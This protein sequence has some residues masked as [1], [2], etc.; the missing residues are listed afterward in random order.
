MDYKKSPIYKIPVKNNI[1]IEEDTIVAFTDSLWNDY[2]DTDRSTGGNCTV[3][4][5]GPVDYISHLPLSVAMSSGEAEYIL[6]AAACMRA[7]HLQMLTYDL[8]CLG[9]A[10][11]DSVNLKC[12]PARIIIDNE[13]AICI[14][15]CNNN[16]AENRHVTP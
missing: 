10:E 16:T 11:Y 5:G 1:H 3:I 8:R 7:S 15:K 4:Q 6:A 14:A 12:Q 13:A 2:V 9:T